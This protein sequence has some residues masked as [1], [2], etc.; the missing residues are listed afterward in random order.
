MNKLNIVALFG[1]LSRQLKMAATSTAAC[2]L[3][4]KAR[5]EY[6]G[7]VKRF[8]VSDD[9]VDWSVE[10]PEYSPVDYTAPPVA[11]GPVW[12]DP[13]IRL[14]SITLMIILFPY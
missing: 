14:V 6:Q 9:K 3:H 1:I 7:G 8:P 2:P 5:T 11:K 13:E 10:W 12:A 4:Y